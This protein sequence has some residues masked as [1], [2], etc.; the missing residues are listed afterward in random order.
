MGYQK[1]VATLSSGAVES[2]FVVN[3]EV[4]LTEGEAGNSP[5][6]M[7]YP[8]WDDVA[9]EAAKSSLRVVK[10]A[11]IP[12]DQKSLRGVRRIAVSNE[13][14][15][16]LAS[17]SRQRAD[18]S[19]GTRSLEYLEEYRQLQ[20][21]A[22]DA[23]AEPAPVTLTT[24]G[25]VFKR[26]SP[27]AK[28]RRVTVGRGLVPHTFGTTKEDADANVR[29][30]A[31]AVSRYALPSSKPASNVFTISPPQDTELKRGTVQPAN[32]QPGGGVEVIFVNGSPDGTVTGPVVIFDR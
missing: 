20:A 10:A 6:Q 13:K 28:D 8:D 17:R 12:R 7:F 30:G 19:A 5:W 11:L 26:F 3:S 25:E 29:T 24:V 15:S 14:F 9:R 1:V 22:S 23:G 2:G 18:I 16:V 21:K 27:Y 4:F 31:D 32:N